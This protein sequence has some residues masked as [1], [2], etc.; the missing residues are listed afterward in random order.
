[1]NPINNEESM[2]DQTQKDESELMPMNLDNSNISPERD[3]FEQIMENKEEETYHQRAEPEP[4]ISQVNSAPQSP[5]E[6][7]KGRKTIP[8][9][10]EAMLQQTSPGITFLPSA[11]CTLIFNGICFIFFLLAGITMITASIGIQEVMNSENLNSDS[12]SLLFKP[13]RSRWSIPI[14]IWTK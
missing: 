3:Q 13:N 2:L 6:P 8:S 14:A 9:F 1:M 5:E 7:K 4:I 11:T 10:L 12:H